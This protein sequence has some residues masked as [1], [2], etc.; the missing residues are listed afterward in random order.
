M[1][2][3]AGSAPPSGRDWDAVL[4]DLDGT[5]V[6]TVELILHCYRHT[7]TTHLGECLPDARWLETIGQPLR[8]QL[9]LFAR[10]E[11]EAA[12]MLET[13]VTF[14][15][16]VHD[17]MVAAFPGVPDVVARLDA[18]GVR[19]AVVTSKGREM[20]G[21]TLTRCGLFD[22]FEFVV[23]A[24]D[25]R[26]G[27]PDPEPVEQALG[28]MGLTRPERVLFVGDSPWDLRSGRAAGTKTAAVL[29]GPYDPGRLAEEEP[30]F[31]VE[32]VAGLLDLAP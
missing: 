26:R 18:R 11:D 17:G 20:A 7:M 27:K 30:D 16:G 10:D 2:G 6:D 8:T 22:A 9:A 5:L 14:Q 12:R 29:W 3:S 4:F 21:R 23:S 1:S 28:R 15:R 31:T 13:Y 25:V 32:S 19:Q 24:D